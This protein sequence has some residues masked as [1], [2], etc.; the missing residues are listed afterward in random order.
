[1]KANILLFAETW[2]MSDEEIKFDNFK[3]VAQ[4]TSKKERKA[5][6]CAVYSRSDCKVLFTKKY[7]NGKAYSNCI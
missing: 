6:G 7:Q 5:Y 3:L 4:I 1:M 2:L